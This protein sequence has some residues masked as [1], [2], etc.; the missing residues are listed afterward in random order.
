MYVEQW[1]TGYE[2]ILMCSVFKF[3]VLSARGKGKGFTR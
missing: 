1:D 2:G 3:N